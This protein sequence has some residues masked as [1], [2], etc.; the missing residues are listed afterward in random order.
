MK[1]TLLLFGIAFALNAVWENIHSFLYTQYK[2]EPIT[3]FILLR[4]TLAD[5]VM[6]AVVAFPFMHFSRLWRYRR[7]TILLW[8]ALA[9]MIELY[10]LSTGRWAYN[11]YMPIIPLFGTGLTPT[12]QLALL[13]YLSLRL[14]ERVPIPPALDSHTPT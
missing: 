3:E 13:G 7:V 6:I 9:V 12:I 11:E 5:A 10:A 4:A 14:A 1:K 2:G 8:L